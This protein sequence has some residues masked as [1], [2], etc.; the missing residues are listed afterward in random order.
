MTGP[1]PAPLPVEAALPA[2][3]DALRGRGRAVLQAPPGAGKSTRVPL[4]LI[5]AGL[6]RGRILMLEP[7]RIAARATAA[8]MAASLGEPP[9]QTVG[10]RMRGEARVSPATRIEVVTE[11]ILTRMIQ[12]DPELSGIG[13]VIFDEFHERSLQADLGLALTLDLAAIRPDLLILVMSATLD[14]GPVAALMGAAPVITAPGRMF[15]VEIRHLARPLPRGTAPVAAMAGLVLDAIDGTEGAVLAFLPGEGEIRQ[16]ARALGPRLP[17]GHVIRPLY[18]ALPAAEQDLALT[19]DPAVRRIVLATNIAETSL[20]IPDVRV[21]VDSGL[22]RRARFD[23]GSGMARLGTERASRAEADQRAGRAGRVAEGL[24]LRAWARAEEGAHP[25]FAEPEITRGDLAPLALDL[26]L[27]GTDRLPFLT[28]PPATALASARR[29]LTGLG[30]LDPAGGITAHGRDLARQPTHPR[31]AHMLLRAGA[32]AAP[33]AA[34]LSERDPV[35]GAGSDLGLRLEAVA[36]RRAGDAP[37]L[38][39]IRAEARRLARGLPDGAA[40]SPGAMAALAFPDRIGQRRPGDGGRYLLSGG[41]G[42]VMPAGDALALAPWIVA[43]E[44]D[45]DPR[46]GTIRLAL[47]LTEGEVRAHLDA[48]IRHSRRAE[49]SA[50]DG[51]VIAHEVETLGAITLS[52]RPWTD[53]PA[54]AVTAAMLEG[55]ATLG[56]RLT[57]A[58]RRLQVRAALAR[59][60][61]PGLPDLSEARLMAAPA[62]WLTPW[63]GGMRSAADWQRF[64]PL[65]ALEALFD[66]GARQRLDALCPPAFV[67]PLGRRIPIDY[68][69]E[70]PAIEIRL[71]EMLGVTRHPMAGGRPIRVT[72]LSPGQRPIQVT[73]D[74]PGFWRSSYPEVRKEMRG[75]YPRH[76]WPEDPTVAEPTLR[77]TPRASSG[78]RA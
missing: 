56:L 15:A 68:E 74:I 39:R 50:R 12:S 10:Y 53:P 26:A 2:L 35:P 23:P 51:R 14:A 40:I 70:V 4:A 27:W 46:E 32:Q 60:A 8:R 43:V 78:T 29:V 75:R 64:D 37:T 66:H 76:P 28:P 18:G 22:V 72:L 62:E 45:G 3:I 13:A 25:A 69:G 17:A 65:P 52:D 36:G 48:D 24:C 31:L 47:P 38:A 42:A 33:L 55:I 61:D 34:L 54:K 58:A 67:T 11:G 1:T 6:V 57:G 73:T 19:P 7:R 41:K 21:V 30:A 9:G 20:T 5:E 44:T 59:A 71:Q 16:L 63:I 77:A 49:W